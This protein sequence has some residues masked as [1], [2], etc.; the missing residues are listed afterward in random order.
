MNAKQRRKGRR[1]LGRALTEKWGIFG[2]VS[3]KVLPGKSKGVGHIPSSW[4]FT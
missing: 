3:V 2:A 4:G 1:A